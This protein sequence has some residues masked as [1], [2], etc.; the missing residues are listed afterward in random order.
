MEGEG[1]YVMAT[2][3][4]RRDGVIMWYGGRDGK[5]IKSQENGWDVLT[6]EELL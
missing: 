2:R 6:T 1:G 3:V 5:R 4:V